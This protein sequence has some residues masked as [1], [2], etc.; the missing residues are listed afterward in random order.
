ME[1]F[2]WWNQKIAFFSVMQ[3]L[4]TI[5]LLTASSSTHF[6]CEKSW[7]QFPP[8]LFVLDQ[9][10]SVVNE[11]WKK[12]YL[13]LKFLDYTRLRLQSMRSVDGFCQV[14]QIDNTGSEALHNV[15]IL[16]NWRLLSFTIVADLLNIKLSCYNATRKDQTSNLL[17]HWECF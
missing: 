14:T 7:F 3:V 12:L 9:Y 5:F 16:M 15:S 13:F 8:R 17:T 10:H 2:I 6:S 4:S 11:N 1:T